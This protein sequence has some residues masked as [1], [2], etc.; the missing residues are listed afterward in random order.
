MTVTSKYTLDEPLLM[1]KGWREDETD[2]T[3]S[4][5]KAFSCYIAV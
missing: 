3:S 5:F 4:F 1:S 2:Y